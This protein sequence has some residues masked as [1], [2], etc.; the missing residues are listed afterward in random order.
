MKIQTQDYGQ[1]TVVQLYGD[2][3]S[4]CT[5]RFQSTITDLINEHKKGIVLDMTNLMFIDGQGLE[6][7][8]WA[9]DYCME[10]DSQF[11][12]AGLDENCA[13]ILEI[14][15]LENEFDCYEELAEAV[16]SFA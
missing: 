11:R 14:T 6:Q 7:L 2:M 3:D 10:C 13:K 4:D 8:L 12:L 1:V 16:K 15:R 5:E 9:K